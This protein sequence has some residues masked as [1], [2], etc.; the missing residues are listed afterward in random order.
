MPYPLYS[1]ITE[2]KTELG[3]GT[4]MYAP[5][6]STGVLKEWSKDKA[7]WRPFTYVVLH[8]PFQN[9]WQLLGSL[10]LCAGWV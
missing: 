2:G 9:F 4:F 5:L 10:R 8:C 6:Y 7:E 1:T 3:Q